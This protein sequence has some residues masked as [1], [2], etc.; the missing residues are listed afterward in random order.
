MPQLMHLR[1]NQK[2]AVTARGK[3]VIV[4]AGAGTGK[5]RVLVERYLWLLGYTIKGP[6]GDSPFCGIRGKGYNLCCNI[7]ISGPQC[8]LA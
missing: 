5:A 3:N 2:R 4:V 8:T 6:D 1:I 7:S